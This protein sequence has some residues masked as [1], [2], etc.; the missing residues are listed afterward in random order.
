MTRVADR[1]PTFSWGQV[2][3]TDSYELV[4]YR[5]GRDEEETAAVLTAKIDGRAGSWTPSLGRCLERGGRYAWSLRARRGGEASAWSAAALFRVA[6]GPSLE[7]LNEALAMLRHHGSS[8]DTSPGTEP[9]ASPRPA[10]AEERADGSRDSEGPGSPPAQGGL[11]LA[12]FSVD[13]AVEAASFLGDGSELTGVRPP[14]SRASAVW[15]RVRS[16]TAP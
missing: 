8:G 5:V 2:A 4:V 16:R 11:G 12:A 3:N 9:A 13:G 7:E 1:C 15:P 10:S 14:A 6:P